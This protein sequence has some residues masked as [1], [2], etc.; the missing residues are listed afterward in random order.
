MGILAHVDSGKTTLSEGLLYLGGKLGKMGRVDNQDAFFD[1][2]ALER[3]RGITIFSKQAAIQLDEIE[4]TLLDTP[5]HV[6]FSAEMERTIWVLDYAILMINGADGIQSHTKTLWNLLKAYEIPVYIFVNKMDQIGAE[7][8]VL[9]EQIRKQFGDGC[10]DFDQ[11]DTEI[12]NEQLAMCKEEFMEEYL[13][14]GFVSKE[15]IKDGILSRDIFPCYFGSALKLEGIDTFLG[16]IEQFVTTPKYSNEFGCKIYKITRDEQGNR[17]THMKITGGTLKTKDTLSRQG[18]EEKVNQI[19]IYSGHK[20]ETVSEASA[21]TICTVLGPSKLLAGH[22]IGMEHDRQAPFLEPVLFYRIDIPQGISPRQILPKLWQIEEEEP[23][24][25]IVWNEELNEIQAQLMGEIQMEILADMI[26]ERFDFQVS[27]GEG[28]IKYKETIGNTVEG[29][30]HFEPLRHYAEVHLLMEPAVNGSG[31]QFKTNCSEDL[32]GRNWQRLILSHLEERMHKGVLTGSPITDITMTLVGGKAHAK[33]TEGGDFREATYRAVRQGLMEA[34][35]VL[36]EPYYSFQLEIPEKMVGRAMMDIESMGGN[37]EIETTDGEIVL[38]IGKAPVS[39]MRNYQREVIAYTKGLGR[40][41]CQF[42]GYEPC[43][44]PEEIVRQLAYEPEHDTEHSSASVFCSSGT[45]FFVPW[46]EV[47]QYMHVEPYLKQTDTNKR[48]HGDTNSQLSS[49]QN[50]SLEEINR[51]MNQ[52]FFANQGKRGMKKKTNGVRETEYTQGGDLRYT[53]SY[54]NVNQKEE[55]LLIDG[56]NIIHSWPELKALVASN[57]D[58][59]RTQ[60]LDVL[61]NYQGIR[62]GKMMVVFDAYKKEG[63]REEIEEHH[64][65][66]VVYTKEAQTA[67]QYIEKF[68]HDQKGNYQIVVATSDGLQQLIVRGEGCRLISARELLEIIE[69]TVKNLRSQY[70]FN[71][72]NKN[73]LEDVIGDQNKKQLEKLTQHKE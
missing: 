54:S 42:S 72:S 20:Y 55:Y 13:E 23:E 50:I 70:N 37:S 38:L 49:T 44:N 67:D 33:H 27:F 18:I 66:Q 4:L 61:T 32:L 48:E 65:V 69:D 52:T 63:H 57:L 15:Q 7:K 6:D 40:L 8:Q 19:R 11:D 46:D 5:G 17:F 51:I 16:G 62:S 29:I 68:A 31:L 9:M 43:S 71:L 56:Y 14:N 60:L 2:N 22:G 34:D 35:S 28:H 24:L 36:L 64:G 10:I 26:R 58:G 1:H 45:G 73:L 21:G 3:E 30:G 41:N 39:N 59:A 53:A 47:K 25:H 12:Q